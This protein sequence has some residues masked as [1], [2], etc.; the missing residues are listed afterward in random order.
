MNTHEGV[1]H[2]EEERSGDWCVCVRVCVHTYTFVCVYMCMC[3][4]N[5]VGKH[6]TACSTTCSYTC[7][8]VRVNVC[9]NIVNSDVKLNINTIRHMTHPSHD[10]L[11]ICFCKLPIFLQCLRC[12]LVAVP[13]AGLH[14]NHHTHVQDK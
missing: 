5:R 2:S 11:A 4:C 1:E 8:C 7:T 10:S 9:N 12:I 14:G 3:A 13:T 6:V